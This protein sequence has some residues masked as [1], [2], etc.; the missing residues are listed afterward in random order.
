MIVIKCTYKLEKYFCS[1]LCLISPSSRSCWI[2]L[3]TMSRYSCCNSTKGGGK[4]IHVRITWLKK[5]KTKTKKRKSWL[6]PV[7]MRSL[8]PLRMSWGRLLE[9]LGS[10]APHQCVDS[11][12]QEQRLSQKPST[13]GNLLGELRSSHIRSASGTTEGVGGWATLMA[14]LLHSLEAV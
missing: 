7:C 11:F 5:T 3:R 6:D 1:K 2:A 8:S 14:A 12:M 10:R 9:C 4:C 13:L